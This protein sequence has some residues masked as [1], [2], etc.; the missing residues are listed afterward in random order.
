LTLLGEAYVRVNKPKKGAKAF[1]K[2]TK[3]DS[4]DASLWRSLAKIHDMLDQKSL[5]EKE[6]KM[7]VELEPHSPLTLGDLGGFYGRVGRFEQ[8]EEQYRKAL[9][10]DSTYF[11]GSIGLGVVKEHSDDYGGA[12]EMYEKA[13]RLDPLN[14]ALKSR[15]GNMKLRLEDYDGAERL[16]EEVVSMNPLDLRSHRNLGLVYYHRE[17][18]DRSI[19]QFLMALGLDPRDALSHF[20]VSRAYLEK[21]VLLRALS[22]IDIV[23]SLDAEFPGAQTYKAYLLTEKGDYRGAQ[24][25]L[26]DHVRR[27]RDDKIAYEL[28]G[29]IYGGMGQDGKA[30]RAY[31][32]A[33]DIDSTDGNIWHSLGL[34]YDR[35]EKYESAITS[36]RNAVKYNPED[37][38]AYNYIGYIYADQ[39]RNLGEAVLLIE[40]ALELEPENGYFRD[41]LGWAYYRLGK[42]DDAAAELEKAAQNVQEMVIYEHLGDVYKDMGRFEDARKQYERALELDI[43]NKELKEKLKSLPGAQLDLRK[44]DL[45]WSMKCFIGQLTPY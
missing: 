32:R 4:T 29:L 17:K 7:A 37:A 41:S 44:G 25:V 19:E 18:Y 10:I 42:L 13:L 28:L 45:R 43:E 33:L 1:E 9:A 15:L 31:L 11:D 27:R 2:A 39:G 23:L 30:E 24:K 16:L 36:F 12:A 5:A 8:A 21:G 26:K 6:F 22:E 35:A 14:G 38:S 40:K 20:Y 3:K 34:L